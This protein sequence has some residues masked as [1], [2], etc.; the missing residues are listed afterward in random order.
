MLNIE[1]QIAETDVDAIRGIFTQAPYPCYP[2]QAA[3]YRLISEEIRDRN[4]KPFV[5][6]AA[7]SAGKSTMQAM[8]AFRVQQMND[9]QERN[10]RKPY[11]F[12]LLSRQGEIIRQNSDE[13]WQYGVRNSIFCAS[14]SAKAAA[15]PIICGSEGTIV[16]A[17]FDRVNE[18]TGKIVHGK[19]KDYA[20]YFVAVDEGHHVSVDDYV[21]SELASESYAL[22]VEN[23][24]TSY[25][26]ILRVLQQRCRE[27]HGRELVLMN[28]T[29]TPYR[30]TDPIINDNMNT[31]GL[32]RKSIVDISTDYLVKFGAVVPTRFGDTSGLKYDLSQFHTDG[33]E[34]IKDYSAEELRQMEKSI[35]DQ[36]TLTQKIML[37]VQRIAKDMHSVLIT[38]AGKKHCQEAAAALLPG[39]TYCI[40]T[41][42][43]Y[44]QKERLA[45]IE[46]IK[47]GKYK[48]TFQIGTMTTGVN[49]PIWQVNVLLRPIGSLTLLTQLLGR[50]MRKL[51]REQVEAGLVKDYALVL[52][53]AGCM[54]DLGSMYHD[55]LLEQYSYQQAEINE[56]YQICPQCDGHN[57]PSAR[58]CIHD[59]GYYFKFR[60]CENIF[61]NA[62]RLIKE[63]C[64]SKND[65][66]ARFC[67]ACGGMM[68]DPNDKLSG[69]HY[70][71][72]DYY[73]VLDFNVKL[74]KDQRAL[75]FDYWLD[76]RQG[77]KF[78]ASELFM[79]ESDLM[80]ARNAFKA[81][82]VG[83]HIAVPKLR[84]EIGSIKNAVRIMNYAPM[85]MKPLRVTHRK[86]GKG[87]DIIA[88]KVFV[89]IK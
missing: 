34:G 37:D 56:D 9:E 45:V 62:G 15:Y 24:R 23:K 13:L 17:L 76:D 70:T 57:S 78:H 48:Y 12:L 46:D 18:K 25:T 49:I 30:G 51:K 28:F 82:A 11:Q 69:T 66:C 29:G 39:E 65:P 43:S 77:G 71:E 67:Q 59:C 81:N 40:I 73:N 14:L 3:T 80:W 2:Y 8:V 85:F 52:D 83:K 64:G 42:D 27:V 41:E 88:N 60:E 74:T 4:S 21:E 72:G 54:D 86:N 6:K 7:V 87:K 38:C 26:I 31:P 53:Y 50:T 63:G 10:G 32:W 58:R 5:I 35:H 84:R 47:A 33:E 16:N 89:E 20:P 68:L 22:M 61:D 19:L 75:V 44:N 55:P 79:P 36:G 1:K